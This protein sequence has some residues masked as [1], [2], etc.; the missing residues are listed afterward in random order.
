MSDFNNTASRTYGDKE[1]WYSSPLYNYSKHLSPA[2]LLD[3]LKK[4]RFSGSMIMPYDKLAA[5]IELHL[6]Y[7]ALFNLKKKKFY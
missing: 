2:L 6:E 3:E 1:N 7:T 5:Y 4:K